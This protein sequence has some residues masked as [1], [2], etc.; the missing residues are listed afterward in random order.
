M[1]ELEVD[2]IL[3]RGAVCLLC[4]DSPAKDPTVG[5]TRINRKGV[6]G[7]WICQQCKPWLRRAL[8]VYDEVV[9][10]A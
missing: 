7:K 3:R 6:S 1:S 10:D 9:S 8:E 2:P 5:L 4:G